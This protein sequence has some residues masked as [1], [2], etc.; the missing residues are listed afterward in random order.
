MDAYIYVEKANLSLMDGESVRDYELA[1]RTKINEDLSSLNPPMP[2][3]GS[4]SS[5]YI[6][7]L[8]ADKAV[9]EF[10]DR[11]TTTEKYYE[12]PYKRDSKGAFSLGK[13][14]EVR[15]KKTFVPV[16][17]QK[18][19]W[20]TAY[21][22]TLPDSAFLHVES[23]GKKDEEGKTVPRGLRH[24][25]Y[26]DDQGKI[27]LPHLRNAIARIPQSKIPGMTAD[28]LRSLQEKAQGI[29]E[30]ENA[31]REREMKQDKKKFLADCGFEALPSEL[32]SG[33]PV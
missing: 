3:G 14:T 24:F 20:T 29:L 1:L 17:V 13:P 16:S 6:Q 9:V 15:E 5:I 23:G 8:Y 11:M 32:W 22:N 30:K 31:R 21:I 10:Y 2:G 27:D 18:A 25:P 7:Y 33:I 26:K 12:V 19:V 28:K 4:S